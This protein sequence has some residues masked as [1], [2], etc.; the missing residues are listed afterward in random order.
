MCCVLAWSCA[1]SGSLASGQGFLFRSITGKPSRRFRSPVRTLLRLC[2]LA[3]WLS[4]SHGLRS[5][6][7]VSVSVLFRHGQQHFNT[8]KQWLFNLPWFSALG[9]LLPRLNVGSFY[10]SDRLKKSARQS[11]SLIMYPYTRV[12]KFFRIL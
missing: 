6:C 10:Q 9:W 3:V 1:V 7:S 12:K 8:V 2:G 11:C 4:W 5:G